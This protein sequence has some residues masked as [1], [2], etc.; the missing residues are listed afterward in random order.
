MQTYYFRMWLA[1]ILAG[2]L[3]GLVFL[4]VALSYA[5]GRGWAD[6]EDADFLEEQINYSERLFLD[7]DSDSDPEMA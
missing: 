6:S 5:G 3:H 7:N 4:P 1:L 2:A